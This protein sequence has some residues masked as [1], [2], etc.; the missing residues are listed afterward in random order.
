MKC[1]ERMETLGGLNQAIVF[2]SPSQY[3]T[4]YEFNTESNRSNFS[5]FLHRATISKL[6]MKAQYIVKH[7]IKELGKE[8]KLKVK[9][10]D[11]FVLYMFGKL[12]GK[13]PTVFEKGKP[14]KKKIESLGRIP[15]NIRYLDGLTVFNTHINPYRKYELTEN[16]VNIVKKDTKAQAEMQQMMD[17]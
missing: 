4:K 1:K 8:A 17:E 3:P 7:N 13:R 11:D 14:N 15:S 12:K 5:D 9:D 10:L 2:V 16:T 6:D